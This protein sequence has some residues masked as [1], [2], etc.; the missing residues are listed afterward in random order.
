[1][2]L[3]SCV[4]SNGSEWPLCPSQSLDRKSNE[5]VGAT[6]EIGSGIKTII[7]DVLSLYTTDGQPECYTLDY[8]QFQ[9]FNDNQ[10]AALSATNSA[11]F[12]YFQGQVTVDTSSTEL[13]ETKTINV[14]L[15]ATSSAW[16]KIS[17]EF[18]FPEVDFS[19]SN[20]V[21]NAKSTEDYVAT[22]T[23]GSGTETVISNVLDEL[24]ESTGPADCHS[25]NLI[26]LSL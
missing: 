12:T 2:Y 20:S 7:T 4:D 21:L 25:V 19:E 11:I 22:G 24:F 23:I 1:M 16:R 13:T 18:M 14:Y 8:I 6:Y 3:K 10:G 5:A 26:E 9:L 17:V 15:K